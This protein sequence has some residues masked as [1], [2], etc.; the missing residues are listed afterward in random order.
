MIVYITLGSSDHS[1]IS[2]HACYFQTFPMCQIESRTLNIVS[3]LTATPLSSSLLRYL[4]H[5]INRT[6][7]FLHVKTPWDTVLTE[8]KGL[9]RFAHREEHTLWWI[10]RYRSV[11]CNNA[12]VT[13]VLEVWYNHSEFLFEI[14]LC[15][16][17]SQQELLGKSQNTELHPSHVS[18]D[19]QKRPPPSHHH[20]EVLELYYNRLVSSQEIC[21]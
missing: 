15:R 19:N 2:C 4:G 8:I 6:A 13:A 11:S 20:K 17:K 9:H 14:K 3:I 16:K 7:S 12:R 18:S 21:K 5:D 1:L 10:K